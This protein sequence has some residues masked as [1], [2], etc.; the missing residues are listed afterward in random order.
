MR[1]KN[2][3][4]AEDNADDA[5]IFSMM[6]KRA[7]LPH[8][9]YTVEDGQQAIDWLNGTGAYGDREKFPMPQIL[10]LDLKMP[11]KTGFEVLEWLRGQKQFQELPVIILS[12]SDDNMDVKRAYQLGVTTYFV[13]SPHLQ[14]VIQYLR[15]SS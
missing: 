12:S 4:L 2:I 7:T 5:L 1:A 10:L 11:V 6:F 8:A 9:L 3:L 13:K 15:L 14:D